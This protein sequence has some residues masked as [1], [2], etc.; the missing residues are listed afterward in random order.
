MTDAIKRPPHSNEAE[1]SLLG[2]V[3]VAGIGPVAAM[4]QESDFY[5][6]AHRLTWRACMEL[7]AANE[8]VDVVSV[9]DWFARAGKSEMVESGA[10]LTG[11]ANE[12]P[13]S[14]GMKTWAKV[15]REKAMLRDLIALSVDIGDRAMGE[16]RPEPI[17]SDVQEQLLS[18]SGSDVFTGPKPL[19]KHAADWLDWM[20]GAIDDKPRTT[21]L[22]DVDEGMMGM[23]GG[24][25]II[26]AGRPGSGK[27]SAGLQIAQHVSR[28][29]P[30]L[31]FSLEMSGSE[32][33]S[34]MAGNG[35]ESK[36]LRN[37]AK[38]DQT[39]HDEIGKGLDM[40]KAYN[41]L[42]DDTAGLSIAQV[43]ARAR[44][45]HRRSPLGMIVIDYLQL[46]SAPG[47]DGR[48]N[49]ISA[50]SRGVKKLAKDL[51]VPV[52]GISQ[53]NRSVE[54][55]Q[56]KRPQMSDLRESGQI[57]Q[58]ADQIIFLY[59]HAY[60]HEGFESDIAEWIRAKHRHG[61]TGTN[62]TLWQPHKTRFA[63]ADWGDVRDYQDMIKPKAEKKEAA[64]F[65]KMAGGYR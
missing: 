52:V 28:D 4:L 40:L 36:K 48:T 21:G 41:L 29:W 17:V 47:N 55:R 5:R 53:L 1:Q 39:D 35:V 7:D 23:L 30:V 3:M 27:S 18:W 12:T 38:M 26:L 56:D 60:Y 46:L 65:N 64:N 44:Y 61:Q 31:L 22:V 25:L 63:N 2:A 33:V 45:A 8:R 19:R 10:Y 57:E 54:S 13:G 24:E 32:L 9:A 37:P 51:N 11:L 59:R 58:D 34:R 42:V 6:E 14:A 16:E 50:I 49:E 20:N 62:Y 15:I 43:S